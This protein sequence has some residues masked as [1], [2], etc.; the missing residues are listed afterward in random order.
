MDIPNG[1]L[2]E[3]GC[4]LIEGVITYSIERSSD[5][6]IVPHAAVDKDIRLTGPSPPIPFYTEDQYRS[7]REMSP[8]ASRTGKIASSQ[9]LLSPA[10]MRRPIMEPRLSQ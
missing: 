6:T 9:S 8:T 7:L 3:Q 5:L 4:A 1:C 2:G 10:N